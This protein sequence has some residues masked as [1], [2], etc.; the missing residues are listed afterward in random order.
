MAA[1]LVKGDGER[2]NKPESSVAPETLR[3]LVGDLD[4]DASEEK[5]R[6]ALSKIKHGA[7]KSHENVKFLVSSNGL[8]RLVGLLSAVADIAETAL[9][10]LANCLT[11]PVTHKEVRQVPPEYSKQVFSFIIDLYCAGLLPFS[12]VSPIEWDFCCW[13]VFFFS[14]YFF[15]AFKEKSFYYSRIF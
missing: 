5:T 9:S 1:K 4:I 6:K 10:T 11:F 3:S 14:F 13:Y 2:S 12:A 15:F 8:A 7:S